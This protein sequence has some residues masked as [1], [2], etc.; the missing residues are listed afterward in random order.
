MCGAKGGGAGGA[1]GAFSRTSP[2]AGGSRELPPSPPPPNPQTP[3]TSPLQQQAAGRPERFHH[4]PQHP[5]RPATPHPI[6]STPRYHSKRQDAFLPCDRRA[7]SR[8]PKR[9]LPACGAA[10]AYLHAPEA[11]PAERRHLC[12]PWVPPGMQCALRH[13][14]ADCCYQG[15]LREEGQLGGV[16]VGVRRVR[17]VCGSRRPPSLLT[18]RHIAAHTGGL[19]IS[20]SPLCPSSPSPSPATHIHIHPV[21]PPAADQRHACHAPHHPAQATP[22]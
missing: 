10:R 6:D 18:E 7:P 19:G 12:T 9:P 8:P 1:G 2:Q 3:T 16:V 13:H 15:F 20:P 17:Y 22:S 5:S 21:A 4:S 14:T 11:A